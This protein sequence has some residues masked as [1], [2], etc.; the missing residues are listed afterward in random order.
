V[1][2][3][4]SLEFVEEVDIRFISGARIG[5]SLTTGAELEQLQELFRLDRRLFADRL[6]ESPGPALELVWQRR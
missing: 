4:S 2:C 6:R 5:V 3:F 1:R